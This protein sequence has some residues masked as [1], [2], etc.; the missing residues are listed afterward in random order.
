MKTLDLTRVRAMPLRSEE[1]QQ[2]LIAAYQGGWPERK[3]MFPL[4]T[5]HA[6]LVD[7]EMAGGF[8]LQSPTVYWWMIPAHAS[9]RRSME[10]FG[11]LETLMAESGVGT[12]IIACEESSPYHGLVSA[13]LPKIGGEGGCES[14]NLFIREIR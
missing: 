9:M 14:W 3:G 12:Y 6:I 7:G 1:D 2:R 4:G 8:C 10:A 5:T 11:C 13:R